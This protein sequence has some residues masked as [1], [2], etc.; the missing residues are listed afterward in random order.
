M[1]TQEVVPA[2]AGT[3]SCVSVQTDFRGVATVTLNRPEVRNAWNP[4][5][6]AELTATFLRLAEDDSVRVAV[7]TGSGT[8]FSA[9]G[10]L[11]WMRGLLEASEDDRRRDADKVA[12][13]LDAL[14]LF[15]KPLVA[16]VNGAAFG[17]GLGLV[18]TADVAIASEPAR[19]GLTEVRVGIIP[20]VISPFVV[21]RLGLGTVRGHLLGGAA[22]SA[23][24]ARA[25]GLVREVVPAAAL[26]EAVLAVVDEFLSSGPEALRR[27]KALLREVS[28]CGPEQAKARAIEALMDV[29]RGDE[30]RDGLT[31]FLEKRRAPWVQ[32]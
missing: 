7:I 15:P 9:G 20:A 26:D 13:L 23:E 22:I 14:D 11:G 31:A 3:S 6:I 10:D 18:C 12:A 21:R 1:V 28:A 2:S 27:T 16:R 4:A 29:W 8:A 19:F 17:G 25:I 24:T 32:A 30:A 5:L